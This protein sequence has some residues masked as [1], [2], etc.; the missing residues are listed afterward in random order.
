MS[1]S[2]A[3]KMVIVVAEGNFW[4][5]IVVNTCCVCISKVC[6]EIKFD[7]DTS[8]IEMA[9]KAYSKQQ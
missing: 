8:K 4:D 2:T 5:F 6:W 7:I 9:I 1:Y 3:F